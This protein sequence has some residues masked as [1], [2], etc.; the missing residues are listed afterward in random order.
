MK[1]WTVQ[2]YC[3][4]EVIQKEGVYK[5]DSSKSEFIQEWGGFKEAYDWICKQMKKR[6]GNP[7]KGV[8][9]PV[10]AWYLYEGKNK[11][12]DMRHRDVR[13]NEKSVLL[14]V[15]IPDN[16]VLLTDEEFWH[17]VL[18]D[19]IYYKA[20]NMKD[21]SDEQWWIEAEKEDKYFNS[22]SPKEKTI[23]KEKSWENIIC[24]SNVDTPYVQA[25][26]WEL[27]ASQIKKVWILRK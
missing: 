8:E 14:E 10:W 2:P 9:Y 1:L 11:R 22:L 17:S 27:K 24:L 26:F 25:T 16:E 13:V 6:I 21:I 23:Y 20:N 15:E 3:V 5:C 19:N 7:P 4:Y 12:P 18:N